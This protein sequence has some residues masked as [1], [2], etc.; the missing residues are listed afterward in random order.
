L[1]LGSRR[2]IFI[3]LRSITVEYSSI[4]SA[5]FL[6]NKVK[7]GIKISNGMISRG[8]LV[9]VSKLILIGF[10]LKILTIWGR[11]DRFLEGN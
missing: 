5:D 9:V 8:E 2:C 3:L 6:A 4:F 7:L 11:V 1:I 10:L